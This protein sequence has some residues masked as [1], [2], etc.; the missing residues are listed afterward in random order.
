MHKLI[1]SLLLL[2]LVTPVQALSGQQDYAYQ[3]VLSESDQSLQRVE[4]P[5]DVILALTRSNLSDLAVFNVNGKQLPHSITRTP[6]TV[7]YLSLELPF[8]KFDRFLRQHSKTVTTREQSQ[9]AD[10]L[11]ELRTTETV[12]VQS[13]RK[14]YLIELSADQKTP[15]FDRIEL[16]WTHEPASQLLEV[17]LEVGNELDQ[18]RVIKSRKSLTN[19]ESKDLKWRSIEK[20][21]ANQKYLRLTPV[22]EVTRFELQKVS[23]HYR[24]SQNA[25]VLTY[26]L[27]PE[28]GEEEAGRFYTFKFPSMVSAEAMR[29]VPTDANRVIS[30]DL[31]ATWGNTE[32]RQR[33]RS[34]FRQ[35]NISATDVK[36]SK[37]IKL[38]PRPYKKIWF[39]SRTELAEAPRVELIYPQ[40]ELIFLGDDMGPYTLAWGNYESKVKATDLAGILEG[41]LQQ[42]RQRGTLV[43]LGSIEQSGGPSRLAPQ[44]ALPWKKWLLW[45]LLILAAIVTGRMA[46]KL[47]N[48]MNNPQ[49][50]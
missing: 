35:H 41:N 48:E 1:Y 13:G 8:H 33:I 46:F 21:P 5:I 3:A 28:I 40:Y 38:S 2:L 26:Q 9:Q 20:I 18:L 47:Y 23:G 42:A 34:G 45:A 50:T 37:P 11:S 15:G 24:E 36:P 4:L 19:Q 29:I 17:K 32:N 49:L 39:T 25:P 14:D 22:N 16:T 30:G 31:Y 43:N 44:P 6:K 12:A 27:D 10:T 7:T